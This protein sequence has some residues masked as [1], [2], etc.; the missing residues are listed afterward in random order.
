MT[1]DQLAEPRTSPTA[2]PATVIAAVVT[3]IV[4]VALTG[5]ALACLAVLYAFVGRAFI[6]SF[7]DTQR[8]MASLFAGFVTAVILCALALAASLSL[9]RRRRWAWWTLLGLSAVTVPLGLMG[10]YQ[11]VPLLV[12]AAAAVVVVLLLLPS[13]RGWLAEEAISSSA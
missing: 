8:F 7:E 11:V 3:T 4:G 12:A 2:V 10:T 6:S 9:L 5:L 1:P 13:T